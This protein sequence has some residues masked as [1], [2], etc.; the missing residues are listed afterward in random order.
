[1]D[2]FDMFFKSAIVICA[3]ASTVALFD[4][5]TSLKDIVDLLGALVNVAGN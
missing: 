2:K 5:S 1:M 3:I 4:I